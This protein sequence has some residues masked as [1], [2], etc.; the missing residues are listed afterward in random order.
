MPFGSPAPFFHL[1]LVMVS[2][3]EMFQKVPS[4]HLLVL[5]FSL[6]ANIPVLHSVG[7][8]LGLVHFQKF[9]LADKLSRT[10]V[11]CLSH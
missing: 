5:D 11:W 6:E 10:V 4:W 9:P 7:M 1:T 3:V 8:G 2:K